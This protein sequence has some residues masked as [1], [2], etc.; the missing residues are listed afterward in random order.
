MN[1][2]LTDQEITEIFIDIMERVQQLESIVKRQQAQ[3]EHIGQFRSESN[4]RLGLL[5][6]S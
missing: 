4:S 2:T 5:R 6:W 3:L 1:K